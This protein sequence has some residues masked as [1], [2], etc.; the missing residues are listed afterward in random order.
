MKRRLPFVLAVLAVSFPHTTRAQA[1]A[2]DIDK[3][4]ADETHCLTL[5]EIR[6]DGDSAISCSCRDSIVDARYVYFTYLLPGKDQNLNGVFLTLQRDAQEMC[7]KSYH[8]HEATMKENWKWNGPEVVRDYPP[9]SEIEHI[10]P[11]SNGFRL[12]KYKVRLV[13]RDSQGRVM[14]VENF[15]AAEKL[16][17]R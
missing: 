1:R 17:V 10:S 8:V 6:S 16:P 3:V 14:K 4:Y 12:V 7:G 15:T 9:D 13:Y 11:D 2:T 5:P